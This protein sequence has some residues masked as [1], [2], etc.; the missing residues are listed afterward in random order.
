[1][2]KNVPKS[3]QTCF[4]HVLGHFFRKNIF[5][6]CSMEGRDFEKFQKRSNHAKLVQLPSKCYVKRLNKKNYLETIKKGVMIILS[7][8]LQKKGFRVNAIIEYNS[9]RI[10]V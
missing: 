9:F 4:E 2:P 7:F 10:K 8:H 1:M 3:V 5:A 6:Q